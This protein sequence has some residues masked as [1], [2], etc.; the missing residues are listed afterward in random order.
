MKRKLLLIGLIIWNLNLGFSQICGTETPSNPTF[1]PTEK[2][3]SNISKR[4]SSSAICINVF[5]HI[6]RN[7]NGT[8]AFTMP[9]TTDEITEELN[10]VYSPHNIIFNNLGTDFI[11]NTSFV[12]LS[13][14]EA[15]VLDDINN[16]S[17][18]IN[19]YIVNGL[20]DN[21]AGVVIN[22]LPNRNLFI[23]ED[24]VN[25]FTSPHEVGHCLNLYHTFETDFGHERTDG[26]YCTTRGDLVCDTPAD[27][28]TGNSNGYNPDM[29]NI[30]SYYHLSPW[31][32]NLDH[33]TDGQGFRMRGALSTES[34][35]INTRSNSCTQISEVSTI[36]YPQNTTVTLS[37]LGGATTVWSSSSNVQIMSS[38]NSSAT[39]R[40]ANSYSNGDGWIRAV[41]SNGITFQ[42]NFHVGKAEVDNVLFRNNGAGVTGYFCSSHYGNEFEILPYVPDASYEVRIRDLST[43]NIVA[44]P[45][46]FTGGIATLPT[47]YNYTPGWYLFEAK[48]TNTCGVGS[49][50]QW[51]VEFVDCTQGGGGGESEYRVYPNPSSEKLTIQKAKSSKEM[52]SKKTSNSSNSAFYKIFDFNSV[53]IFKGFLENQ[54]TIDVSDYK[55]GNYILKIYKDGKS[56]SHQIIIN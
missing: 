13:R 1:Y 24:N 50:T 7:T 18:A 48:G 11:D 43:N 21:V 2:N 28:R 15:E 19:Y 46:N 12:E 45:Y 52:N 34:I 17:D 6:V 35:L 39:I 49:W 33:F 31:F 5:F 44:G 14:S 56:E 51:E 3:N 29:T 42:E 4:G 47:N 26:L 54:T 53:L 22:G 27:N 38:N 16:R 41:L 55:K 30:M 20:W 37:N 25:D 40:G 32:N 23:E 9:L 10:E 36:C 8:D